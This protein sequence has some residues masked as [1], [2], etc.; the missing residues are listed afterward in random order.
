MSHQRWRCVVLNN[1]IPN[2]FVTDSVRAP[3]PVRYIYP[4]TVSVLQG[5]IASVEGAGG[6]SCISEM[7]C[8]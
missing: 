8:M 6:P 3:L 2:A 5:H 4:W 1:G 7:V